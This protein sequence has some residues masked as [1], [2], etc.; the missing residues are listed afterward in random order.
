MGG[1]NLR[2]C[3]LGK[4]EITVFKK[5][6][7]RTCSAARLDTLV[8]TTLNIFLLALYLW[9]MSQNNMSQ[10]KSKKTREAIEGTSNE[11]LTVKDTKNVIN[12]K[13]SVRAAKR[14]DIWKN[15]R[16]LTLQKY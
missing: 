12:F 3:F 2:P 9:N 8:T 15:R 5:R 13:Q 7:T 1:R 11:L 4:Y 16:G 10:N 14:K 6:C